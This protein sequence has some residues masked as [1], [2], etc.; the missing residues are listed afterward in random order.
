MPLNVLF[1]WE[2]WRERWTGGPD[3][4]PPFYGTKPHNPRLVGI[5]TENPLVW[6]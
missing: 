4:H 6:P 3:V 2:G 1:G 5:F